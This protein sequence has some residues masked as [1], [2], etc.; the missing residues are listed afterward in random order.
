MA[1]SDAATPEEYIAKLPPERREV[2]T[3]VRDLIRENIADGFQERMN[4]GMIAYEVPRDRYPNTYN[5]QPLGYLALAAQKRHYALYFWG[6]YQSPEQEA[7]FRTEFER[8]GKKLDMGKSCLRFRKL[9]DLPLDVIRKAV[10]SSTPG[11]V[12]ADYEKARRIRE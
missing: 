9:D 8:A 1:R 2:M 12:I 3:A 5:D 7:W 6:V 11:D 10:A 4:W